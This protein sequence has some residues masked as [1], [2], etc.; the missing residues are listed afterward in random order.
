MTCSKIYRTGGL[1]LQ[2]HLGYHRRRRIPV[3]QIGFYSGPGKD[4]GRLLRKSLPHETA[5]KANDKAFFPLAL[6]YHMG[7]NGANYFSNIWEG[8][9]FA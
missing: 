5:V 7:C 2:N 1:F 8:K 3:T 9:L 4:P 6:V